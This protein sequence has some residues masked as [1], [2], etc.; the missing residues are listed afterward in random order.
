MQF[1]TAM[2]VEQLHLIIISFWIRYFIMV[3][4]PGF[5]MVIVFTRYQFIIISLSCPSKARKKLPNIFQDL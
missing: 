3:E 4:L 1:I 5:R 2:S